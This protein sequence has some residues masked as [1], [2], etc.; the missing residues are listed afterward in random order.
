MSD[1]LSYLVQQLLKKNSILIDVKELNFQIQSH[2]SYPSLHAVTG[3]LS[4]F[5]IENLAIQVPA[6]VET[7]LQ[8]PK[9]FLAELKKGDTKYYVVVS[10]TSDRYKLIFD[11]NH[12]ESVSETVFLDQFTGV[13]V[14]VD[15]GDHN[16]VVRKNKLNYIELLTYSSIAILIFCFFLLKPNLTVSLHFFL[17][18]L[19][20]ATSYLIVQQDLGVHSKL[21]DKICSQ[22]NKTNNCNTVLKSK[23]SLIFKTIKL[24]DV[25]V[26][27][28][29]AL[30]VSW[31]LL[32]VSDLN[33]SIVFGISLFAIPAIIYSIYYQYAIAK[34]W[35]LLCLAIASILSLQ[36]SL[37]VFTLQFNFSNLLLSSAMVLLSFLSV[38]SVWLFIASKLRKV[39]DYD[40]LKIEATKFKRNYS[41][42][43]TLLHK[44]KSIDITIE[45]ISEIIFGNKNSPLKLLVITNPFCGF[46]KDVHDLVE[47]LLQK[48]SEQIS[49]SIRFN[50]NADDTESELVK[51]P[52]RLLE[53]YTKEGARTCLQAMH[54]IYNKRDVQKWYGLYGVPKNTTPY[55]DVLI[56]E[57]QWCLEHQINFTPELLVNGFVFPKT[58]KKE[59]LL[60][61]IEELVEDNLRP[62]ISPIP[63]EAI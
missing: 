38:S 40:L 43:K 47:N 58:Y 32:L 3:V 16:E 23:G 13:M 17:S 6:T 15:K 41:V 10:T 39:Q 48:Y 33:Y 46:C 57:K 44:N 7:L 26:I 24:S 25:C 22:E 21:V 4:H 34:S 14:A 5:N 51:L 30:C 61:F 36:A 45:N 9:C 29:T 59:E 31:F 11:V 2:P 27:Y 8:L 28:F 55:Q 62:I 60:Y 56:K 35:C 18:M 12:S 50:T 42:F 20:V 53:I 37:V 49:I 52:S 19:G 1:N 54:A 63:L